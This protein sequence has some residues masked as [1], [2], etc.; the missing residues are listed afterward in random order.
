MAKRRAPGIHFDQIGCVATILNHEVQTKKP[1]QTQPT[2][3][4]FAGKRHF[5]VINYAHDTGGTGHS[6]RTYHL[7]RDTG[8]DFPPPTKHC[9]VRRTPD[10]VRLNNNSRLDLIPPGAEPK[11]VT[12][13]D[14]TLK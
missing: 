12:I 2:R 10:N 13:N 5:R 6:I 4:T 1:S 8:Q 14:R 3:N 9:G 7:Y 11:G